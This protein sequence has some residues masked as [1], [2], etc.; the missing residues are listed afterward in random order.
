MCI[1]VTS[2][3][4]PTTRCSSAPWFGGKEYGF[5]RVHVWD[6]SIPP[7]PPVQPE[8]APGTATAT[9]AKSWENVQ[10]RRN[11]PPLRRMREAEERRIRPSLPERTMERGRERL[12][13]SPLAAPVNVSVHLKGSW[14]GVPDD[15]PGWDASGL[16]RLGNGDKGYMAGWLAGLGSGPKN[17]VRIHGVLSLLESDRMDAD[18]EVYVAEGMLDTDTGELSLRMEPPF[19]GGPVQAPPI[20]GGESEYVTSVALP[21]A[22]EDLLELQSGHGWMSSGPIRPV[23]SHRVPRDVLV[24]RPAPRSLCGF[25][26]SARVKEHIDRDAVTRRAADV[27]SGVS[28]EP[29]ILVGAWEAGSDA[30]SA[31]QRVGGKDKDEDKD[32]GKDR[33]KRL[34]NAFLES[35]H[36]DEI[37]IEIVEGTL[38]SVSCGVELEFELETSDVAGYE[39]RVLWFLFLFVGTSVAQ[40]VAF[41]WQLNHS[42]AQSVRINVSMLSMGALSILDCYYCLMYFAGLAQFPSLRLAFSLAAFFKFLL[43]LVYEMRYVCGIWRARNEA[44]WAAGW[45]SVRSRVF[46]LYIIYYLSLLIG[47]ALMHQFD[48]YYPLFALLV[49]SYWIPQIVQNIKT[50]TSNALAH[51]YVIATSALRL[52]VPAYTQLCPENIFGIQTSPASFLLLLVF[53]SLQISLLLLQSFFGPRFFVPL[54]WVDPPHPYHPPRHVIEADWG[55]GGEGDN[56]EGPM[57]TICMDPIDLLSP[58]A[59]AEWM[60][61]PC[62]HTFHTQCLAEWMAI[63]AEC[64]VCRSS[65]PPISHETQRHLDQ[66]QSHPQ[67]SPV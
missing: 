61:T 6:E 56:N 19:E 24:H 25:W 57:C 23:A 54:A 26:L 29:S 58:H 34:G 46:R 3:L 1:L 35:R 60:H 39:T 7:P 28:T 53:V 18:G 16:P 22:K 62:K 13:L 11:H 64:P 51:R 30:L 49:H 65:L 59:P 38:V 36:V 52:V 63:R 14:T 9:P 12:H 2:S 37:R 45:A 10:S 43:A 17:K 32:E 44:D 4:I 55:E 27:A 42:T 31:A 66:L 15:A 47:T 41:I 5:A 21:A 67:P 50:N 8:A 40:L 20:L 33:V 48:G